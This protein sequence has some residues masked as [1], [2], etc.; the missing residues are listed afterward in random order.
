MEE[1]TNTKGGCFVVANRKLPLSSV[2]VPIDVPFT[3]TDTAGTLSF[4]AEWRTVPVIVEADWDRAGKE[5]IQKRK[6]IA[7]AGGIN[8]CLIVQVFG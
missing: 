4:V 2:N 7:D 5:T 8:F 1:K 3:V 6:I